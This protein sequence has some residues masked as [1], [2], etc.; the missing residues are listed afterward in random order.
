MQIE[1][2]SHSEFEWITVPGIL[3]DSHKANIAVAKSMKQAGDATSRNDATEAFDSL[4]MKAAWYAI[5]DS[6]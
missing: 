4:S 2:S 1:A 6:T 3:A 5:N